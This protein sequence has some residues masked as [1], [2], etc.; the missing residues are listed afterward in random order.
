MQDQQS[1]LSIYSNP[2]NRSN[3]TKE[4]GYFLAKSIDKH[5][6]FKTEILD[7]AG[8]QQTRNIF[9]DP[10]SVQ[11]CKY[12]STIGP[13]LENNKIV[14]RSIVGKPDIFKR[15][16]SQ[17]TGQDPKSSSRRTIAKGNTTNTF[18]N[19]NTIKTQQVFTG[20]ELLAKVNLIEKNLFESRLKEDQELM[21]MPFQKKQILLKETRAL[22]EYLK[23]EKDQNNVLMGVSKQ[24]NKDPSKSL[25]ID[26]YR[27]RRKQEYC[28]T[29][30]SLN[31]NNE[32]KTLKI[33]EI[34]DDS[35]YPL[36][37]MSQ[38]DQVIRKPSII[39]QDETT[40][41]ILKQL[42]DEPV[43]RSFSS[44]DY[45]KS[46]SN[47]YA[48]IAADKININIDNLLVQGYSKLDQEIKF[49]TNGKYLLKTIEKGN[50][51]ETITENYS[52]QYKINYK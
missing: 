5:P 18:R 29:N 40:Q 43:Y 28:N 49:D 23:L 32:D 21:K 19:N 10:I 33:L 38:N 37:M 9:K 12:D 42:N 4:R 16:L 34:D 27:F 26:C 2:W 51:E 44:K 30:D 45:L 24:V 7:S 15:K 8:Q 36:F 39:N 1:M 20:E 31:R 35:G 6:E 48:K 47:R 17:L 50:G 41:S 25:M 52:G 13:K 22:E 14:V 46:Q 11:L 3:I